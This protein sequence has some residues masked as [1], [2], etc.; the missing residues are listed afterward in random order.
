MKIILITVLACLF[1]FDASEQVELKCPK[2]WSIQGQV[3]YSTTNRNHHTNVALCFFCRINSLTL[4]S[5][6]TVEMCVFKSSGFR[7]NISYQK[8]EFC[9][10]GNEQSETV[11]ELKMSDI[12]LRRYSSTYCGVNIS[13][14]TNISA[15]LESIQFLP[16]DDTELAQIQPNSVDIHCPPKWNSIQFKGQEKTY[17]FNYSHPTEGT[18]S[19]NEMCIICKPIQSAQSEPKKSKQSEQNEGQINICSTT[20]HYWLIARFFYVW[21]VKEENTRVFKQ[22]DLSRDDCAMSCGS[23][24]RLEFSSNKYFIKKGTDCSEFDQNRFNNQGKIDDK[25]ESDNYTEI[26]FEKF[27]NSSSSVSMNPSSPFC[28]FINN[29]YQ[30]T[31]I[32]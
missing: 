17:S 28:A 11:G 25:S 4:T 2:G 30:E 8:E 24:G 26:N 31:K 23:R 9:R 22:T 29:H 13:K 12:C 21:I 16:C 18:H 20:L 1:V 19:V 7:N 5:F 32:F 14:I 27:K 6:G 10:Y 3:V 15:A